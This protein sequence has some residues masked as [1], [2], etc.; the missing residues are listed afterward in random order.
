M[1]KLFAFLFCLVLTFALVACKKDK[2]GDDGS[3]EAKE[4][5]V[6]FETNGGSA[7]ASQK[8]TLNAD[9][10]VSFK[11]P[12]DPLKEGF[13][14]AG[15]Y[16]DD[17]FTTEFKSLDVTQT[18]VTLYA[19]WEEEGLIDQL[20][21]V[22]VPNLSPAY[23]IE[24]A[25]GINFTFEVELNAKLGEEDLVNG[26]L[27]VALKSEKLV[28]SE[29]KD[30]DLALSIKI[31]ELFVSELLTGDAE[32]EGEVH[33]EGDLEPEVSFVDLLV[34]QT[35]NVFLEEGFLYL[36]IPGA[37]LGA[38]QS[39]VMSLDIAQV[40]S[41]LKEKL[42]S[43]LAVL[44][45]ETGEAELPEDFDVEAILE[46]LSGVIESF[47][48]QIKAA[49]ISENFGTN[50]GLLLA[51]LMPVPQVQGNKSIYT[52]D[53]TYLNGALDSFYAFF[54]ENFDDIAK[55]VVAFAPMFGGEEI[56]LPTEEEKT[57]AI[58][59]VQGAIETI[60][61]VITLGT[62]QLAIT[63]ND[64]GEIVASEL[65]VDVTVTEPTDETPDVYT[66][67]GTCGFEN[68]DTKTSERANF[69]LAT[70]D[71]AVRFAYSFV[72]EKKSEN[73]SEASFDLEF[74][75]IEGLE[76]QK[77]T[78]AARAESESKDNELVNK[79]QVNA[80]VL[81]QQA[82]LTFSFKIINNGTYTKVPFDGKD[83]AM[84]MTESLLGLIDSLFESGVKY[85]YLD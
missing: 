75:M 77:I 8:V 61:Q 62:N 5:T 3:K 9:G 15:W 50:L 17:K 34:G 57:G 18:S 53:Q 36:E 41:A 65:T 13:K 24:L 16:L 10:T 47:V 32:E 68:T 64:E 52:I 49:G 51:S 74:A 27:D 80:E 4:I 54:S 85:P 22:K 58:Q 33:G 55:L 31:A 30:I 71:G 82:S 76:E 6:N 83:A 26:R 2:T 42:A 70:T 43:V 44:P 72:A 20:P 7:I 19:K 78:L 35:F 45:I 84:D 14:F 1:K 81:G 63:K 23:E 28:A 60:K 59:A 11:L 46:M 21:A 67:K 29:L 12:S 69:N 56:E 48:E 25:Q 66:L 79:L 73:K 39:M 38:E 37:L 40:E